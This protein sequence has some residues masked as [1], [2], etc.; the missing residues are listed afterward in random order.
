MLRCLLIILLLS[1]SLTA[2]SQ[3]PVY[4]LYWQNPFLYNIAYTGAEHELVSVLTYRQQ[5]LGLQDAPQ[6]INLSLHSPVKNIFA[7]G[8]N[9]QQQQAALYKNQGVRLSLAYEIPLSTNTYLRTALAGQ[10]ISER[11]DL[12]SATD[13][14]LEYLES[15]NYTTPQSRLHWQ[16][17]VYLLHQNWLEIGAALLNLTGNSGIEGEK[18]SLFDHYF[19]SARARRPLGSKLEISPGILVQ[20]FQVQESRTEASALIYWNK[21]AWL[22]GGYRLGG[23]PLLFLGYKPLKNLSISYAY[24]MNPALALPIGSDTHEIQLKFNYQ[25]PQKETKPTRRPRYEL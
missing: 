17:G 25:L 6:S 7:V 3:E 2:F 12:S 11:Y 1:G 21:A 8:L 9:V 18:S 10:F 19:V 13:E 5:W 15:R 22:G 23:G 16:S 14:Q 20:K 24:E 4:G